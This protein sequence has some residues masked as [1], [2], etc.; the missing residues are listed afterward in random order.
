VSDAEREMTARQT[1]ASLHFES[2]VGQ[3]LPHYVSK[4]SHTEKVHG[5]EDLKED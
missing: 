4:N 2:Q 5:A 1:G 3:K